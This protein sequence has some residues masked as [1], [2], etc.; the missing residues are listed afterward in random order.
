MLLLILWPQEFEI[1]RALRVSRL[2]EEPEASSPTAVQVL[3]RLPSGQRLER[4]FTETDKLEVWSTYIAPL[5]DN[6]VFV[7]VL[8]HP[9]PTAVCI[10]LCLHC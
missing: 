6:T 7:F 5:C 2:P 9:P 10:R 4:R 1:E 8:F 3:L